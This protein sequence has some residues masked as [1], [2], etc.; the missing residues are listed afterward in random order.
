MLLPANRVQQTASDP[1]SQQ[2]KQVLEALALETF[3]NTGA[4]YSSLREVVNMPN[5][6]LYRVLSNLIRRDYVRQAAKGDPY[7]IT[8]AGLKAIGRGIDL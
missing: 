7:T 4:R 8:G 1:L 3:V 5:S 6:T 2:Q